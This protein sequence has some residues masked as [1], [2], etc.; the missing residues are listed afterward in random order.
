MIYVEKI[1][2]QCVCFTIYNNVILYIS[3][4]RSSLR[5]AIHMSTF[6]PL[7]QHHTKELK[8]ARDEMRV[9]STNLV[10]VEF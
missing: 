4:I 5:I 8:S 6:Q 10:D 9:L 7:K 3:K 2:I 1:Y